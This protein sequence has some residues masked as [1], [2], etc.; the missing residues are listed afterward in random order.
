MNTS[1][2][3]DKKEYDVD[4]HRPRPL[5][6]SDE[7]DLL[8]LFSVMW[9]GR[10][11]IIAITTIFAIASVAFAL[12]LPDIYKSEAVLA[13]AESEQ[14][15]GGLAALAGQFG[16]L[17]S[18]AGINL[19]KG[20]TDKSQLAIEIMK[21]R[22]FISDFIQKHQ[23]LP[24]LMAAEKWEM[25]TNTLSYDPE[26]YN[27]ETKT[28]VREVK[29]P[30]KPEPSMQ[31]AYKVFMKVFNVSNTKETGMVTVSI[32]HL[33]PFI[34]QKWVSWLVVDINHVMKQR[35]VAEAVRG[36]AFINKQLRKTNVN[37]MREVLYQL[38]EQTQKTIMF[39][40]V[41][42]E[43]VF[44]T[45]DPAIVS[46]EKAKPNHP[47]IFVVG[48]LLGLIIGVFFVWSNNFFKQMNK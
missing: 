10:W 30:F 2:T 35:D 27:A 20:Q 17:A 48:T 47:I 37:D 42:D 38:M 44:K 26:I 23:I 19:G 5:E 46:E 31:E 14:S 21:S 36:V 13:P 7:I 12:Y 40:E 43:Y 29:K 34:A 3:S 24:D 41:R 6:S 16:G 22:Q 11:L 18:I 25:K 1:N 9:Q 8:E 28:W 39:A 15:G 32:E 33:S 4:F 45:I